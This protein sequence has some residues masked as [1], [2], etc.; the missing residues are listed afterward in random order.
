MGLAKAFQGDEVEGQSPV[1]VH[2]HLDW[3]QNPPPNNQPFQLELVRNDSYWKR[4]KKSKPK[5]I[6]LEWTDRPESEAVS[7]HRVHDY[8]RA[9]LGSTLF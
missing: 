8:R 7:S 2:I 4:R 1:K 6:T 3:V 5:K 9:L